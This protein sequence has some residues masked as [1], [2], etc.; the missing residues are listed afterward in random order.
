MIRFIRKNGLP[1]FKG[2][3]KSVIEIAFQNVFHL[4]MYQNNIFFN[5]KNLFLITTH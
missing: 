5:F 4:E 3:L 2:L 1:F